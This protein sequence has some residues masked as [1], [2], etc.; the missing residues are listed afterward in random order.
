M[1]EELSVQSCIMMGTRSGFYLG[2]FVGGGGEVDPEK[3]F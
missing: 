3:K 2:F 1:S